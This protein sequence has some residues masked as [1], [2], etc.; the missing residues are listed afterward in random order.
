MITDFEPIIVG[1]GLKVPY[2]PKQA[3]VRVTNQESAR[4]VGPEAMFVKFSLEGGLG[5]EVKGKVVASGCEVTQ[6]GV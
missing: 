5:N 3:I 4:V 6:S 2:A 1:N